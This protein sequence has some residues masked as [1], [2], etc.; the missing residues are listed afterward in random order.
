MPPLKKKKM[1]IS[2]IFAYFLLN[3]QNL[4]IFENDFSLDLKA[5]L[6]GC[7][8][9]CVAQSDSVSLAITSKVTCKKKVF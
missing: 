1:S 5:K 3:H 4:F 9:S 7:L 6:R 2:H 8:R